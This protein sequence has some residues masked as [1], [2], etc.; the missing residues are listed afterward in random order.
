MTRIIRIALRVFTVLA[1]VRFGVRVSMAVIGEN[2]VK[3]I[4]SK[5][6]GY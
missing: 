2:S 5:G 4:V 1:A 6:K 3:N